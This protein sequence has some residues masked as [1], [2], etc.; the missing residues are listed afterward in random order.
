MPDFQLPVDKSLEAFNSLGPYYLLLFLFACGYYLFQRYLCQNSNPFPKYFIWFALCCALAIMILLAYYVFGSIDVHHFM[1]IAE[2]VYSGESVYKNTGYNYAPFYM[3][4][5]FLCKWISHAASIPLYFVIKWPAILVGS[6]F[7]V[8]VLY[9]P[10]KATRERQNISLLLAFSPIL[11]SV[12]TLLGQIDIIHIFFS[13]IAFILLQN[14]NK[15]WQWAAI[16]LG[17]AIYI[18]TPSILLLPAFLAQFSTR[19]SKLSF[20]CIALTPV[21]L[22]LLIASFFAP[23]EVFNNVIL[24]RGYVGGS[25]G[26]SGLFWILGQVFKHIIEF[27]MAY[28]SMHSFWNLYNSYGVYVFFTMMGASYFLLFQRISLLKRI[29]YTFLCFYAFS[30]AVSPQNL[31]WIL[32]FLIYSNFSFAPGFNFWSILMIGIYVPAVIG[33]DSV[34]YLGKIRYTYPLMT[35]FLWA[36]CTVY[37]LYFII[38]EESAWEKPIKFGRGSVSRLLL[39][40]DQLKGWSIRKV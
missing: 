26:F 19:K 29:V 37:L 23:K 31:V 25:W 34:L 40:S 1:K 20:L 12:S 8:L 35:G 30:N 17:L 39:W 7:M 27:P 28:N 21:S 38:R 4:I 32:P 13:F 24:F 5:L 36:Y 22:S 18:K 14:D 2:T 9:L 10:F 6:L 15:R 3:W 33:H 11:I 16:C